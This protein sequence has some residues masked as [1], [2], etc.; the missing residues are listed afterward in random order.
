MQETG[1]QSLGREDPLEKG[2]PTPV[3]LPGN[4]QGKRNLVGCSPWG[5]KSLDM[6]EQLTLTHCHLQFKIFILFI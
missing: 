2:R 1:V 6:T 4:F 3:L 5:H